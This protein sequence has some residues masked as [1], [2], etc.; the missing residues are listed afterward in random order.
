MRCGDGHYKKGLNK[1]MEGEFCQLNQGWEI[2]GA[3][4]PTST[5]MDNGQVLWELW[6]KTCGAQKKLVPRLP[7]LLHGVFRVLHC[8]W[9]I[10][11]ICAN[12]L[13][14]VK[15]FLISGFKN[16]HSLQRLSRSLIWFCFLICFSCHP[17]KAIHP[18]AGYE[19]ISEYKS[20]VYYQVKQ[21]CW[22]E[23]VKVRLCTIAR[24]LSPELPTCNSLLKMNSIP[25]VWSFG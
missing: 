21:P 11:P 3:G 9:S 23:T 6:F 16:G 18:G 25:C 8:P 2:C 14:V 10:S 22:Y 24:V 20:V 4:T 13:H 17:K 1:F 12:H 19:G 7:S 15:S 5:S